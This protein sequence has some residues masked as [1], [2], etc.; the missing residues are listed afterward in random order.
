MRYVIIVCVITG[1]LIWDL[2][3]N[4]GR[5]ISQGVRMLNQVLRYLGA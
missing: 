1:F 5:Y 2:T 3:S 4:G